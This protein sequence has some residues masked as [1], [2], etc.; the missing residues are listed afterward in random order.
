MYFAGVPD[1]NQERRKVSL[2]S[3]LMSQAS[4]CHCTSMTI[5]SSM[6][7]TRCQD[8]STTEANSSTH[9]SRGEVY[10]GQTTA[11]I[12]NIMVAQ[13]SPKHNPSNK[14]SS[15]STPQTIL[16]DRQ[17][18]GVQITNPTP[19]ILDNLSKPI[20]PVPIREEFANST[21]EEPIDRS[22]SPNNPIRQR[23]DSADGVIINK[24]TRIN[25][26]GTKTRLKAIQGELLMDDSE[27]FALNSFLSYKSD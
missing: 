24:Y 13:R 20:E 17:M 25:D 15:S 10:L 5:T 16:R 3:P 21:D 23:H 1:S 19:L 2:K 12:K 14:I 8:S 9:S 26:N 7:K 6:I 4:D 11:S 18:S 22:P 27:D